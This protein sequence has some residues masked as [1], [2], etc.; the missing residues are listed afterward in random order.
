[1]ADT[2]KR[3][4]TFDVNMSKAMKTACCNNHTAEKCI[5]SM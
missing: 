5:S 4:E 3:G 2:L 1:M